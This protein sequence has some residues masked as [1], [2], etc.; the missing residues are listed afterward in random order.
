MRGHFKVI[1]SVCPEIAR[2]NGE[3]VAQKMEAFFG[4]TAKG[5][6]QRSPQHIQ[7]IKLIAV[8]QREEAAAKRNLCFARK[9]M[10]Y[11][12]QYSVL[13]MAIPCAI[14]QSERV[15]PMYR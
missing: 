10:G 3:K 12:V 11:F 14:L 8:C 15:I 1:I 13:K 6:T 7:Y 2:E 9:E 4:K 5:A